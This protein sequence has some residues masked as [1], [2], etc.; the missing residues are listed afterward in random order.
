MKIRYDQLD[1]ESRLM[2]YLADELPADERHRVEAELRSNPALQADLEQLR[3]A[4][5]MIG[6]LRAIDAG[7]PLPVSEHSAVRNVMEHMRRKRR[8]DLM[9]P[10]SARE[11]LRASYGWLIYP[12]GSVAAVL[13]IG[14]FLWSRQSDPNTPL[15]I[16]EDP[17][18]VSEEELAARAVVPDFSSWDTSL[19]ESDNEL[20]ALSELSKSL[21]LLDD[22]R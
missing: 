10:T 3:V 14:M 18:D 7:S 5:T 16:P 2:L 6:G 22:M 12:I 9:Q 8:E 4:Q 1:M 11:R 19:N 17:S 15:A 21:S 20:L 13:M